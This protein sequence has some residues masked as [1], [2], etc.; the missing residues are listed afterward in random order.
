[1]LYFTVFTVSSWLNIVP[2][3]TYLALWTSF[4]L[5]NFKCNME[6]YINGCSLVKL[7]VYTHVFARQIKTEFQGLIPKCP[8]ARTLNPTLLLGVKGWRPCLAPQPPSVCEWVNGTVTV[9]CFGSSRK[10]VK[11]YI[12]I[13]HLTF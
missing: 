4:N 5:C 12:S 7:L 8:W 3:H 1:M 2:K 10:V 13:R 9:M 6:K 11:C